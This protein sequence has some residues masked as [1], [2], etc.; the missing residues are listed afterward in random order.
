MIVFLKRARLTALAYI[1]NYNHYSYNHLIVVGLQ[2]HGQL[3][4]LDEVRPPWERQQ[5]I[6]AAA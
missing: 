5:I 1:D 4:K 6:A 3:R 2:G